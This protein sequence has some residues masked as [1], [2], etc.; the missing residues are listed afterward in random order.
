MDTHKEGPHG[1]CCRQDDEAGGHSS[2]DELKFLFCSNL[3][4]HQ[5]TSAIGSDNALERRDEQCEWQSRLISIVIEME[6][7]MIVLTLDTR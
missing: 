7:V 1:P 6:V 4:R 2:L 5:D 3:F